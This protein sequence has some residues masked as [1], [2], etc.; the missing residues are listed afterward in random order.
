MGP[1]GTDSADQRRPA[2]NDIEGVL[3]TPQDSKTG[4]SL[5]DAV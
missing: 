3:H 2:S 5:S 1:T 4:A